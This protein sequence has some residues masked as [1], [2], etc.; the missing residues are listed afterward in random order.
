MN[1]KVLVA[2]D[3]HDADEYQSNEFH[4]EMIRRRWVRFPQVTSAYCVEFHGL[5][6][7][8]DAIAATEVDVTDAVDSASIRSW[9]AVCLVS[10]A[11]PVAL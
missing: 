6:R 8:S 5:D 2:V 9:D 4:V 7:E 1:I 3:L 10:S 11:H